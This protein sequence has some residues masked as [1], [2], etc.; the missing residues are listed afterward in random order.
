MSEDPAIESLIES[1]PK[2]PSRPSLYHEITRTM[3]QP[4]SSLADVASLLERDVAI[5][6]R[7]LHVA[8][9]AYF[10][11]GLPIESVG[12]AV[13]RLGSG[14]VRGLVLSFETSEGL[15][16]AIRAY[17]EGLSEHALQV[18]SMCRSLAETNED[19]EVAFTAGLLHDIGEL[20]YLSANPPSQ[21]SVADHHN[22][23]ER[24]GPSSAEVGA[25][26]LTKW[27]IPPFVSLAVRYQD[28]PER[29]SVRPNIAS[30][31][32]AA[33]RITITPEPTVKEVLRRFPELETDI[34]VVEALLGARQK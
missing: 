14:V 20:V 17:T 31:L 11:R 18:A 1:V 9:S 2:L 26:L 25:Y 29:F 27:N 32:R 30:W 22:Q 21:W 10:S 12:A 5:S 13:P 19:K 15:P 33:S 4:Q 16:E 24:P 7:V 23:V 28:E 3:E 8:N 6:A 34:P